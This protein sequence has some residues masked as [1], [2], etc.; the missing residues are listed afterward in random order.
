MTGNRHMPAQ[1]D[2]R[3]QPKSNT[4]DHSQV[5]ESVAK[6]CLVTV[7]GFDRNDV[8]FKSD[9]VGAVQWRD[10]DGLIVAMLVKMKPDVWGFSRR[11][12]YDWE[13]NLKIYGN[14][15]LT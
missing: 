5:S 4:D 11:G 2:V 13:E 9:K 8:L 7:L 6:P 10:S 1:R 12:D 14:S 3:V 15:D